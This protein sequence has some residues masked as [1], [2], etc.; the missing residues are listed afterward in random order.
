MVEKDEKTS[1]GPAGFR[2]N[3]SCVDHVY[4]RGKAIQRRKD[5]GLTMYCFFLIDAPKAYDRVWRNGVWEN[6]L[7]NWDQR[8]HVESGEKM[9][10]CATSAVMLDGEI[11]KYVGIVQGVA[12]ECTLSPI[13]SR[14]ILM[15][16]W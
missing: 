12:Q 11:S 1:E 6:M 8:K 14:Y 4:T 9:A 5:A 2:P 15:T 7:E 3:R 10:E 16:L 13:Y